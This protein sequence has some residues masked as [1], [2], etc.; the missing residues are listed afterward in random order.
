M[1]NINEALEEN[2]I[3]AAIRD[4]RQ[5]EC[6]AKSSCGVIFML[7]GNILNIEDIIKRIKEKGKKVCVH[8]DFVD[9]LGKDNAAVEFLKRAGA[10]G[11][12]QQGRLLSE[13]LNPLECLPFKDFLL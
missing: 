1:V 10:D 4:C 11:I 3:I 13:I 2:P 5:W 8:L 9:G 12:I 7:C 6:A